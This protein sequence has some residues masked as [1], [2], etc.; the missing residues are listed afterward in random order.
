MKAYRIKH[1][2]TGLYY[3]PVREVRIK[4]SRI[5][6]GVNYKKEFYCKSNLSKKGKVYLK[7]VTL[8][9]VVGGIMNH[10]KNEAEIQK[11]YDAINPKILKDGGYLGYDFLSKLRFQCDKTTESDWEVEEIN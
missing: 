8:K 4:V 11:A 9:W 10:F 1:K 7:T 5:I 3:C 6:E 2:P